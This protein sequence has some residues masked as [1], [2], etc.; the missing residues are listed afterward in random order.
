MVWTNPADGSTSDVDL[1]FEDSGLRL[2][3]RFRSGGIRHRA[4]LDRVFA[5]V[6]VAVNDSV[7]D[8]GHRASL[9]RADLAERLVL[10]LPRLSDDIVGVFQDHSTAD[11]HL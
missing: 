3:K 7:P 2:G 6:T 5:A 4:V 10:S 11:R 8:G 1:A 9:M